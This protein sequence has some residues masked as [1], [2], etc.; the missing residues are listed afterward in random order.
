M[1]TEL[2]ET[3]LER[4]IFLCKELLEMAEILEPGMSLFR[5]KLLLE[6]LPALMCRTKGKLQNGIIGK[7]EAQVNE[8]PF[9]DIQIVHSIQLK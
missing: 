3:D 4:K 9:E 2:G 1:H 7:H 6:L 8:H 5:A